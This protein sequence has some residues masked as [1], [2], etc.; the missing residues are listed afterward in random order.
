MDL[1]SALGD[2]P[3]A[4][5]PDALAAAQRGDAPARATLS[6]QMIGSVAV[7]PI[8]GLIVPGAGGDLAAAGI[9]TG[10]DALRGAVETA[11]ADSDVSSIVL[12]I[13][14]PGGAVQG[15]FRASE[16][17]RAAGTQKPVVAAVNGLALSAGY[18]LAAAAGR[19]VLKSETARA[20]SIGVMLAHADFSGALEKAGVRVTEF[21]RGA[22]K[23]DGSPNRPLSDEARAELQGQ[24]DRLYELLVADIG[25]SRPQTLG[26]AGAR[27][28]EARIFDG[29]DAIRAGLADA[30][31]LPETVIQILNEEGNQL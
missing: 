3:L 11:A 4:I 1:L 16:S 8:C 25:E 18:V 28:S 9:A 31:D 21:S 19:I 12:L 10:L 17:I 23:T 5:A 7:V 14:S 30:V 24:V 26:T 13:D 6:L 20:G 2:G 29:S 15:L 22:R 27:A